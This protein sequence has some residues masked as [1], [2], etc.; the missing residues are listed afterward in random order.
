MINFK[1]IAVINWRCGF[2]AKCLTLATNRLFFG[3]G[4]MLNVKLKKIRLILQA[5]SLGCSVAIPTSPGGRWW[6]GVLK[7]NGEG[8]ERRLFLSRK[9]LGL[10]LG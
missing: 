10:N 3:Q 4:A 1:I 6:G 8:W 9:K 7:D 5:D 2:K